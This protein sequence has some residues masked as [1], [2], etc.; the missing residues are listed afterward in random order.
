M[1]TTTETAAAAKNPATNERTDVLWQLSG[2]LVRIYKR[3]HGKGPTKTRAQL[4]QDV[5]TVI[6]EG[7]YLPAELA[8]SDG[9]GGD[10]IVHA[11]LTIHRAIEHELRGTV[12][13]TLGRSVSACLCA[14]DPAAGLHVET[15]I[16]GPSMTA[17]RSPGIATTA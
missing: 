7:R 10:P 12:E 15:Y 8:I 5:L 14:V 1:S 16:L 11:R 6:H 9:E 3:V 13:E 2:A 17:L 4:A